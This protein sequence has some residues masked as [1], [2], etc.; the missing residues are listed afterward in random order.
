[1]ARQVEEIIQE[2]VKA[3]STEEL[4]DFV[5]R[6]RVKRNVPTPSSKPAKR[7]MKQKA[8]IADA[9]AMLSPEEREILLGGD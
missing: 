9:L 6:L 8:T 2:R 3:M 5:R 1:M 7:A 4:A